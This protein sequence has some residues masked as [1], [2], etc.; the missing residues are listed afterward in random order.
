MDKREE[1]EY[2]E[3]EVIKDNEKES[4]SQKAFNYG[5]NYSEEKARE[6]FADLK[7]GLY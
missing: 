4:F 2:I 5:A 7:K 6:A 3:V 1:K